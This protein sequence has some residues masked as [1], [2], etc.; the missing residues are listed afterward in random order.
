MFL[1]E[2]RRGK[3]KNKD[4][5]ITLLVQTLLSEDRIDVILD[6]AAVAF[7]SAGSSVDHDLSKPVIKVVGYGCV[8]VGN[9]HSVH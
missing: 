5:L 4:F 7:S 9:R 2:A 1:W 3:L 6:D 8:A